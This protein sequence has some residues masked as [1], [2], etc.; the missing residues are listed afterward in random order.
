MKIAIVHHQYQCKGGMERYLFDLIDGFRAAG[1]TVDLYV[2]KR[3]KNL[4]IREG[5][6][7]KQTKLGWLPRKLKSM[8]LLY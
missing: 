6:T 8:F 4:E 1:D 5:L 7:V 3:D 2:Y